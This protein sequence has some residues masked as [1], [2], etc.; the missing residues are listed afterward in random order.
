MEPTVIT[1]SQ[2]K[3]LRERTGV[4]M[5]KCK[6]A[7]DQAKG[8][9]EEAISLLRKA[10]M[11]SAVKKEGR[12]TKEGTII[13]F[14]GKNSVAILEVNSETDFVAKNEKFLDF[15]KNL[16]QELTIHPATSVEAF[17]KQSYSKDQNITIDQ[18]RSLAIQ[19]IGENIQIRRFKILEKKPN[20]SFGIY[21]HMNGK[22]LSCVEVDAP[23]EEAL[24][25]EV[26]M[27]VA[28]AS[29]EYLNPQEVPQEI[30]QKEQEIAKEQV[31]GKP[32]H[33]LDK[34]VEGKLKAF[35]DAICL[36]K[37]KYI[38]D[39][40]ISVEQYIAQQAQT[41]GKTAQAVFF[42]RWTVGQ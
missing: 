17:L 40:S 10:G 33:I 22:I 7:L 9:M 42:L 8:N 13:A 15:C 24:A 16:A 11:A 6:E 3:E 36:V 34:I 12:E 29:P 5:A 35:F 27:H 2:V 23:Q 39:D 21:S 41:R 4:G 31:K 37:Q 19:T 28:A 14:D 20:H 25:K 18:F 26:A 32:A 1:A 38:R 30:L